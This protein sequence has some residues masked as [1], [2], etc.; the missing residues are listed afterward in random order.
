MDCIFVEFEQK[1]SQAKQEIEETYIKCKD[2]KKFKYINKAKQNWYYKHLK[3]RIQHKIYVKY[4]LTTFGV[5]E[6][7]I[8]SILP[9]AI[10]NQSCQFIDVRDIG[11]GD[12]NG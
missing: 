5:I 1:L 10:D 7:H 3:E 2:N 4:R 9:K 12:E 11:L 8:N 6:R